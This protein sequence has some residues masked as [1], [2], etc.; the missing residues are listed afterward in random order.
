MLEAQKREKSVEY[1]TTLNH[2]GNIYLKEA[3]KNEA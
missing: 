3:K 1:A 2:I